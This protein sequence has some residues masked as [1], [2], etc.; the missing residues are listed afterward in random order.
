M[1][2][3]KTIVL[4][5]AGL[6]FLSCAHTDVARIENAGGVVLEVEVRI[7]RSEAER[8][9]GLQGMEPLQPG[10]GLWI[11]FPA[12]GEAC[13]VNEGV[14]YALDLV[15]VL[16]G[17]V[18]VVE[19]NVPAGASDARCHRADAVLELNAGDADAVTVGDFCA[20]H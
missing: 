19:R 13:I 5:F 10:E 16:E 2:R 3:A 7:A 18:E 8:R 20:L 9:Q 6:M 11:E 1:I 12:A 14:G 4:V 17:E 15:F